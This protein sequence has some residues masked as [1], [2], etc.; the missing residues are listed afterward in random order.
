M[1]LRLATPNESVALPSLILDVVADGGVS[2]NIGGADMNRAFLA[3][4]LFTVSTQAE[5][6]VRVLTTTADSCL[7]FTTA[8]DAIS[9]LFA[10]TLGF[11]SG[12]AQGTGTDYLRNVDAS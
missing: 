1:G 10:W 9:A 6:T 5:A 7:A 4:T 11:L 8:M 12:V 3:L 2:V